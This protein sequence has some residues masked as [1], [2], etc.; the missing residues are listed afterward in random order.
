MKITKS[1]QTPNARRV[2]TPDRAA[3]AAAVA[4]TSA[5]VDAASIAGVPESELTP[6]V[7]EALFS[8][9]AEVRALRADLADARAQ[10]DTLKTLADA[11]PLLGILNR[12]AFVRELDRALAMV[13]R[14]GAAASLVFIDLD[15]LKR[16][17]DAKGHA[18]GDQALKHVADVLA[19]NIRQTDSLGRLGGDEFG[20]IL[21]QIDLEAARR[22]ADALAEAVA[23][24]ATLS[25]N[26][27][28]AHSVSVTCGVVPLMS[29]RK[30]EDALDAA[31]AAMYAQKA[32]R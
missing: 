10:I 11:D 12:R 2:Q 7:K 25:G 9:M 13:E 6:K 5:P 27:D 30:S 23:A 21:M 31:D 1:N 32:S 28:D 15:N 8:L 3:P 24:P 4:P 20:L 22:K 16:I 29:G 26:G 19:R 18:A 14:Y 17:N